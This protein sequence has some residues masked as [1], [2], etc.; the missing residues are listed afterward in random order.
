M[1]H[2]VSF[3]LMLGHTTSQ[4]N[5]CYHLTWQSQ[6]NSNDSIVETNKEQQLMVLFQHV[7]ALSTCVIS[8][9]LWTR[10]RV[11]SFC[12]CQHCFP[13][14]VLIGFPHTLFYAEKDHVAQSVLGG[15]C[16]RSQKHSRFCPTSVNDRSTS[17]L[18]ATNGAVPATSTEDLAC[19]HHI[20]RHIL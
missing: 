7:I 9:C 8:Y 4:I 5:D 19:L 1:S 20:F 11:K 16:Q 15:F 10:H 3:F 14:L 2:D 17:T 12:R 6:N 13:S 18:T